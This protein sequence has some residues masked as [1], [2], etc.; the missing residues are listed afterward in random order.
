MVI[1]FHIVYCPNL[2]VPAFGQVISITHFYLLVPIMKMD[3]CLFSAVAIE[4]Y[5]TFVKL[6]RE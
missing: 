2:F 5:N 1:D 3:G 4:L 6:Q